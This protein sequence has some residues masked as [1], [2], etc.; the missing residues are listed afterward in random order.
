MHQRIEPSTADH[1]SG[2]ED[3]HGF[4]LG[5]FWEATLAGT[6]GVFLATGW[7]LQ[8]FGGNQASLAIVPF[9][10]C[11]LAG[12]FGTLIEAARALR[13]FRFEIDLLMLVAAVGA[14]FLGKWAEGGLLLFLFSLAHSLEHLAM[15]RA[16]KAIESLADLAP[17][18]LDL[19]GLPRPREMTGRSL[20][21]SPEKL[22][23]HG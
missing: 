10:I 19:M 21:S 9:V 6:C 5:P 23:G 8:T 1:S 4:H 18:V 15:G 3:H 20:L 2:S 22:G 14:A 16:K 12:G 17:T 11:Y 7:L 13:Q